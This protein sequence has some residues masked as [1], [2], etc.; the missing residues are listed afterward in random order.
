VI[1][2]LLGVLVLIRAALPRRFNL[3]ISEGPDFLVRTQLC[4][5]LATFLT[6][7]ADSI[8]MMR[9]PSMW[10]GRVGS[11]ELILLVAVVAIVGI[12]IG[13]VLLAGD[14]LGEANAGGTSFT[15]LIKVGS[16]FMGAGATGRVLGSLHGWRQS[17]RVPMQR[18]AGTAPSVPWG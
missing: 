2:G 11:S 14:L 5:A 16:I 17:C 15:K 8:A 18:T 12:A 13:A 7:I 6:T 10:K 3:P 9:H 4:I 1:S